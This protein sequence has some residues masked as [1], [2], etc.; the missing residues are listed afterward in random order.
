MSIIP[1]GD[2]KE[3]QIV[4]FWDE[5]LRNPPFE[6]YFSPD[7]QDDP[8]AYHC[9]RWVGYEGG[10]ELDELWDFGRGMRGVNAWPP[11]MDFT[12]YGGETLCG[13]RIESGSRM[14]GPRWR[15]IEADGHPAE[16]AN[17]DSMA[18]VL[19]DLNGITCKV[20][21]IRLMYGM[22]RIIEDL[23]YLRSTLVW[24]SAGEEYVSRDPVIHGKYVIS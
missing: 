21:R 10:L 11:K 20:C 5:Y 6:V 22:S 14:Y 13:L 7:Y 19:L 16:S 4:Y 1:E 15:P 18:G 24:D 8:E 17:K 9:V 12:K 3:E 23:T 2:E